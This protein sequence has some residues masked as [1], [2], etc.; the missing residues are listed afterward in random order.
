MTP[1]TRTE[2]EDK[3]KAFL[4]EDFE[5]DEAKILP[6]ARLTDDLDIDSLDLVDIIVII[7]KIFGFMPR[8]EELANVG[9]FD[10]LCNYIK[11]RTN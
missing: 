1:M 9:T 6:E 2:I 11:R 3:V 4:I 5:I 7:H 10:E 8:I